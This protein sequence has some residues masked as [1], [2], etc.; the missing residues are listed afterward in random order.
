MAKIPDIAPF[1]EKL[2]ELDAQMAEPNFY[3]DQRKAA[4]ISR[5]HMRVS[6]LIEKFEAYHSAQTQIVE[7]EAMMADDTV[8]AELREMAAEEV[9]DLQGQM[10]D[11]E[12]A[13]LRAMVPPDPTD[14]RNSV[15]EIRGGAGGDEANIFAGDLYR[16][17]VPLRRN[18][19]LAR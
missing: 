17:Y 7:N 16:M 1:R 2:A 10:D 13:V 8:E 11:L 4:E 6:S 14:S 18:Q 12:N 19:G 9:E 15:M 5:E 3:S